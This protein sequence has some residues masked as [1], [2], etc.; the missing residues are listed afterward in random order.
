MIKNIEYFIVDE[1]IMWGKVLEILARKA[2]EGVDVRVMYDG[3]NEFTTLSRNYPKMLENLGIKCKVF[4]PLTPFLSTHYNYRDHRKIM[5]IDGNTAFTGGI[6]FADRYI[7]RETVHG[8]RYTI[9]CLEY[10][11]NALSIAALP[12]APKQAL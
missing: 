12:P 8:S 1:G 7:N 4:A 3:T 2:K 10:S 5:V 11:R 6:N 9:Y